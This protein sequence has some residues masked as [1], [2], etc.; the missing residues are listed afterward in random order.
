MRP[1]LIAIVVV[2]ACDRAPA[3]AATAELP[4]EPASPAKAAARPEPA[5]APA[6]TLLVGG[7]YVHTCADATACPSLLQPAGAAHCKALALDGKTW[8]LP[9]RAEIA[10][11]RG[12]PGLVG[13][14]GFHW[15]GTPFADDPGQVWIHD[16]STG[17]E[18]TIPPDRKP[19]RVRCVAKP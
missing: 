15:S 16:P 4:A 2:F 10:A 9:E 12:K 11:W 19:F 6:G 5:P 14:E 8:R 1:A 18:T 13:A 3:P 7:L 17:T